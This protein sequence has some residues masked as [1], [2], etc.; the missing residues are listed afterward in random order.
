MIMSE[1]TDTTKVTK[2]RHVYKM[3]N[4]Y[5]VCKIEG[6]EHS[7]PKPWEA[8]PKPYVIIDTPKKD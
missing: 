8:K 1:E 5:F 4:G 3:K 7:K 6:C 2:H